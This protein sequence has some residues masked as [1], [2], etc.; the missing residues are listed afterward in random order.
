LGTRQSRRG[1]D[2]LGGFAVRVFRACQPF[3]A[4]RRPSRSRRGWFI[5]LP[6]SGVWADF[7]GT[8]PL[9]WNE[10]V[11]LLPHA[12]QERP[13]LVIQRRQDKWRHTILL[14]RFASEWCIEC[15]GIAWPHARR[16][17]R[18]T[19]K[20]LRTN[21][22]SLPCRGRNSSSHGCVCSPTSITRKNRAGTKRGASRPTWRSRRSYLVEPSVCFHKD[23]HCHLP[24]SD[25]LP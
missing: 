19:R 17:G 7:C 25:Y 3:A 2:P 13:F 21:L 15:L 18:S 16:L 14:V 9:S 6:M 8:N 1:L 11:N 4:S 24:R 10:P 12:I 23:K 5:R 22:T 20:Y